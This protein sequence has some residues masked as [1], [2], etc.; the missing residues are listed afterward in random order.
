M[1]SSL[2]LRAH[3]CQPQL[4]PPFLFLELLLQPFQLLVVLLLH[5]MLLHQLLLQLPSQ[6]FKLHNHFVILPQ[7]LL[8]ILK[9]LLQLLLLRPRL[10]LQLVSFALRHRE[11]AL[12]RGQFK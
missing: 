8:G 1:I 9:Q 11:L 10:L 6:L 12:D 2:L 4:V 3:F 7:L 5:L